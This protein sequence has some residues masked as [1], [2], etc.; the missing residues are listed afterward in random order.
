MNLF[1]HITILSMTEDEKRDFIQA[2]VEFT[3]TKKTSRGET[4]MFETGE[5]DPRYE[6]I[7][8][9]LR[10]F[11]TR[12]LRDISMTVP[13]LREFIQK[14]LLPSAQRLKEEGY[15]A[16]QAKWQRGREVLGQSVE[17]LKGGE[18]EQALQVLDP[19]IAEAIQQNHGRWASLLCRH[20]A[21]VARSM[22]DRQ[23]QI[24]YEE[25]ALP[26]A[27]DYR[28]AAYNF[29]QLL[30]SDGQLIRAEYYA[31]EAYRQSMTRATDADSDLRAAILR[32]WPN[33][34]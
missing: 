1:H 21:V 5:S 18:K 6:K 32:Q 34:A 2:G 13:T 29:A 17:L 23:R 20:A 26:F 33:V 7:A 14:T 4:G 11:E 15:F 24:Q 12:R 9:L 22:G 16:I 3:R 31:S 8:A 10:S 30:L 25:Q 28:F 19:A 27:K